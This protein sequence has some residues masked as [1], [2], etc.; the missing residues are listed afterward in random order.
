LNSA[1]DLA[2]A[3]W[4][5]GKFAESESLVRETLEIDERRRP[6]DWRRFRDKS[7]LGTTLA[8]QKKYA[9]AEPLLLEGYPG[10]LA[11]KDKIEAPDF[12]Y[13]DRAHEWL[14]QLYE[15]WGK[16]EKVAEWRLK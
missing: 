16:P 3:Y 9:E 1:A 13:I 4:S 6:E 12:Y 8:A 5:Q 10:M 2:L 14:I 15:A 11:R 7:L